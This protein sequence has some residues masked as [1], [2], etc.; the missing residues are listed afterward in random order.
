MKCNQVCPYNTLN[1]C[2]VIE[3]KGICP[4]S[5]V[6]KELLE[7]PEQ[8]VKTKDILFRGKKKYEVVIADDNIF[9]ICPIVYSK[10]EM[11]VIV[12]YAKAEI[13]ANQS[14]INTLWELGFDTVKRGDQNAR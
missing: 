4:I 5:N 13:Y 12:K 9:V 14:N 11:S 8:L 10:R 6:R 3:V 7:N 1:G 2:K